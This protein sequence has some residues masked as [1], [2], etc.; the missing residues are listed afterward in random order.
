MFRRLFTL[1]SAVSLV[2]CVAACVLW[3]RSYW[4]GTRAT[5][6]SA[7]PGRGRLTGLAVR[8]GAGELVGQAVVAEFGTSVPEQEL[9]DQTGEEPRF[10]LTSAPSER[11]HSWADGAVPPRPTFDLVAYSGP[12]PHRGGTVTFRGGRAPLWT[13]ALATAIPPAAWGASRTLRRRRR[14]Q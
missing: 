1:A 7:D 12:I 14:R 4:V 3:V 13:A 8:A 2:L 10:R 9:L 6:L 11:E 5:Y